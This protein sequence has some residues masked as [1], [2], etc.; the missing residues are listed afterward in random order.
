MLVFTYCITPPL[1]LLLSTCFLLQ[2]AAMQKHFDEQIAHYGQQVII[3]L[4]HLLQL[5]I[6]SL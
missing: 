4:V 6:L 5:S 3:N 1:L 2:E